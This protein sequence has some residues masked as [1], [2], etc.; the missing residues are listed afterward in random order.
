MVTVLHRGHRG[1]VLCLLALA[2]ILGTGCSEGAT[3]STSGS[4]RGLTLA[5]TEEQPLL[6]DT[7]GLFENVALQEIVELQLR[8]DGPALLEHLAS[9]SAT[10]RARAALALGSVQWS[11][12]AAQLEALLEDPAA[13]VRRDAA[14]ALGQ[15]SPTNPGPALLRALTT[16]TEPRVRLRLIEALG[17]VGDAS[18]M[19]G[20]LGLDADPATGDVGEEV[21][22]ALAISRGLVRGVDVPGGVPALG[23]RLQHQS[24]A[25]REAAAWYFGRAPDPSQ[26]VDQ[27]GEIRRALDKADGD[28][29]AAMH[30]LLALAR[31]RSAEDRERLL[32]WLANSHDWRNRAN[33]ARGLGHVAWIEREGVREGLFRALDDPIEQVA[34]VAARSL[35]QGLW[36]PPHV[37]ARM[38]ARLREDSL[39]RWRVHVPFLRQVSQFGDAQGVVEWT[40][41]A[42]D[43]HPLAVANGLDA[44]AQAA[45]PAMDSLLLRAISHPEPELRTVGVSALAGSWEGMIVRGT[46][47]ADILPHLLRALVDGP[48]PAAAYAAPVLAHPAFAEMGESEDALHEAAWMWLERGEVHVSGVLAGSLFELGDARSE[49]L[50]AAVEEATVNLAPDWAYLASLGPHP[51]MHIETNRGD[52][53]VRLAA[54]EAP[55][56]VQ[57]L[58][59]LAE[60]GRHDGIPLHRVE[61]NFVVQGGDIAMS[62]GS[63]FPGIRLP[64]EFTTIPFRRGTLGMA[65]LGKD[66]EGSQFFLTHSVQPHLDGAF[67]SFG[68]V[69]SGFDVMDRL[70]VG[71]RVVRLRVEPDPGDGG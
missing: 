63:G 30:L 23:A 50:A 28:D 64:S 61:A 27:V 60:A 8:R 54:E 21:A 53:V 43:T 16:E 45:V 4:A 62:D 9:E 51:R 35:T 49:A 13:E 2:G 70:G 15:L 7:D 40:R 32:H 5:I 65:S 46:D 3:F 6:R 29:P 67:T 19:S 1:S 52:I 55:L 66:T 22:R 47:V 25:V 34:I 58:A 44:L 17:K 59:R 18:S 37:L 71:D 36:V 56:T 20:L 24:P 68:W 41:R 69:E 10:L 42:M 39:D 11:G 57:G 26:M 14:F 38:E 33:A 48:A 12:A 31:I